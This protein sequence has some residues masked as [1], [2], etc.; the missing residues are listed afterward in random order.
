MFN[1]GPANPVF[2]DGEIARLRADYA[3]MV[4]LIDDQI[5]EILA[6]LEQRAEL[7]NT[8][9]VLTSDHGEMN[10][11]YG[12]LYKSNF[13][14]P[15]LRVP[16]IV[17]PPSRLGSERHI[18][19]DAL[20]ELMDVGATLVDYANGSSPRISA[21]ISV[22]PIIEGERE[23]HRAM[24][25]SQFA[26]STMLLT[27]AWKIALNDDGATSLLY[28]LTDDSFEQRSLARLAEVA[29]IEHSLVQVIAEFRASTPPPTL[30]F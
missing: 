21:A 19:S 18:V 7:D 17:R 11:D 29:E 12:L 5:G 15:A 14:N 1:P 20:V 6:T 25:I 13:L 23:H 26:G 16:L 24:V 27:D 10:G 3:G 9:V 22:R 28:D 4:A 8:V 2:E 30:S